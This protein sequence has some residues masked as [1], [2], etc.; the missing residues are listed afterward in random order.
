M[1][2]RGGKDKGL[3]AALDLRFPK[4]PQR[5]TG[6]NTDGEVPADP[7]GLGRMCYLE[8]LF[9]RVDVMASVHLLGLAKQDELVKKEHVPQALLP[10]TADDKLVL[11]LQLPLLLQVH[12]WMQHPPSGPLDLREGG[13]ADSAQLPVANDLIIT[14][15]EAAIKTPLRTG[16]GELPGWGAHGDPGRVLAQR[17]QG[18]HVL[19]LSLPLCLFIWPFLTYVLP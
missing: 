2:L 6:N 10:S 17:A 16:F 1:A 18:L 15:N 4:F 19:L 14:P 7:C 5:A 9:V 8:G 12:L 3:L 11:T 13:A